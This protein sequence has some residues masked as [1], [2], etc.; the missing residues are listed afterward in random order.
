MYMSRDML[1]A[2]RAGA[3][4]PIRWIV[5]N[6]DGVPDW[7]REG[8]VST[9]EGPFRITDAGAQ[10]VAVRQGPGMTTLPC[11]VGDSDPLLVR[12]LPCTCTARDVHEG[13]ISRLQGYFADESVCAPVKSCFAFQLVN[14]SC[15]NSRAEAFMH[16]RLHCRTA[17]FPPAKD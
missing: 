13:S 2:W 10:I 14:H 17:H 15:N 1:V 3:P 11:F 4:D 8:E 5:K 7:A 9:A 6:I 16:R 12:V